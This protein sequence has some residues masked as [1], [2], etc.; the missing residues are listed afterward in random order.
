MMRSTGSLQRQNHLSS[1]LDSHRGVEHLSKSRDN[2]TEKLPENFHQSKR[3][4]RLKLRTFLLWFGNRRQVRSKSAKILG[5]FDAM[6]SPLR[7]ALGPCFSIFY[8]FSMHGSSKDPSSLWPMNES[9][10]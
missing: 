10:G 8:A 2:L 9:G 6:A 4:L 3:T 1:V 5:P 7:L